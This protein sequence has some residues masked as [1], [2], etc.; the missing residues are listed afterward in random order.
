MDT[1]L[2]YSLETVTP[3]SNTEL[4]SLCGDAVATWFV[5]SPFSSLTDSHLVV[6]FHFYLPPAPAHGLSRVASWSR[7]VYL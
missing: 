6:S 7:N 4:T 3:D 1:L 5:G 2:Y